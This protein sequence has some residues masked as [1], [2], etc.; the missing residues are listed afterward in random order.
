[1]NLAVEKLDATSRKRERP[2]EGKCRGDDTSPGARCDVDNE[3]SYAHG[4]TQAFHFQSKCPNVWEQLLFNNVG[5]FSSCQEVPR[6]G[7]C[8]ML[9]KVRRLI[10]GSNV[11]Q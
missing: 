9:A 11:Q 1:M 5:K 8:L 10:T 6:H 2:S 4:T 7:D 3:Y